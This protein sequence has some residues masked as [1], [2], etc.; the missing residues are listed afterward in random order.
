MAIG[1]IM[2]RINTAILLSVIFYGVFTPMG[3]CMRLLRKDPMRRGFELDTETYRVVQQA[4]PASH[5]MRQ[6]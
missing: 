4:R 2:G 1:H 3:W 5:M 6:F